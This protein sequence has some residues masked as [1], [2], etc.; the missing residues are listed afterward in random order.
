MSA[1]AEGPVGRAGPLDDVAWPEQLTAR[2]VSPGARPAI[3]GY[4]VEGDLAPHYSLAET[5]L[6]ALTGE[7]PAADQACAFEIA[8]QFL[9][10]APVHEAPTHAAVVAR[11]C[12]VTT[13]AI[14]G[15]AA[16]GLAEQA[17]VAVAAHATW[18]HRLESAAD[19]PV[20]EWAPLGDDE[21]K[22]VRRLR[23]ALRAAGVVLPALEGDVGRI[24]ALLAT[25]H[26]AGLTRAEQLEAA[27]VLARLPA[28]LAEALA[29]PSHSFRDYPVDVP[30]IRYADTP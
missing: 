27:F 15:T 2:V 6:L 19:G 13:S 12:N 25:L 14:I 26:F 22:S 30:P 5:T 9:S 20:A 11:I 28:A 1:G 24:A 7:L 10:P 17:R 16:I 23:D 21:R 4:D 3:H 8:L 29:T 18:V